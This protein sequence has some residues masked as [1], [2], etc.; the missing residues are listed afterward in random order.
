MYKYNSNSRNKKNKDN[1]LSTFDLIGIVKEDLSKNNIKINEAVR[2]IIA[3]VNKIK[4]RK[5]IIIGGFNTGDYVKN[6]YINAS[7]NTVI[8]MIINANQKNFNFNKLYYQFSISDYSYYLAVDTIISFSIIKNI[9]II[10]TIVK[11][12]RYLRKSEKIEK[13]STIKKEMIKV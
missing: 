6:A 12:I 9:H 5:L 1:K 11:F 13:N 2:K 3:I 10:F 4:F 8:C 7:I